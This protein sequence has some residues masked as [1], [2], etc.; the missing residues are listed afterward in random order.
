MEHLPD[1][2]L[3]F[4]SSLPNITLLDYGG[5]IL[6]K[7]PSAIDNTGYHSA[8]KDA[9]NALSD[10]FSLLVDV[11]NIRYIKYGSFDGKDLNSTHHIEISQ[12]VRREVDRRDIAAVVGVGG[13]DGPEVGYCLAWTIKTEK[14]I[15]LFGAGQPTTSIG[16]EG[17]RNFISSVMLA[18]SPDARGREVMVVS[19]DDIWA[20]RLTYKFSANSFN[21]FRS[22]GGVRLGTFVNF[23]P[24]FHSPPGRSGHHVFEIAHLRPKD[25]LPRVDVLFGHPE[26]NT[27]LLQT[28]ITSGSKGLILISFGSG[29]WPDAAA[30]EMKALLANTSLPVVLCH[31]QGS[32][33][34]PRSEAGFGIGAGWLPARAARIL[35]QLAVEFDLRSDEIR[36]LFRP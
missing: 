3:S 36:D 28:V 25:G 14:P 6:G 33:F 9:P 35:L 34:V 2:F 18:I 1:G 23:R 16:S 15:I 29:Y 20:A 10:A 13:T 26:F 27:Q 4:N 12:L 30:T 22:Q 8:V 31:D 17:S 21:A 5:T 19:G 32:G 11:V 24:L 7:G